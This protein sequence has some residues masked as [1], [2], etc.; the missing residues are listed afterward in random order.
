MKFRSL[1]GVSSSA[2]LISA[3]SGCISVPPDE[4]NATVRRGNAP[5]SVVD[6]Q[7]ATKAIKIYEAMP[8]DA[9]NLGDVTAI[10]CHANL[11]E[12]KPTEEIVRG[13]LLINAYA[14]GADAI[15]DMKIVRQPGNL[16]YNCYFRLVG[17]ARA[18]KA[19]K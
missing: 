9:E 17:T 16:G 11:Y 3:L 1:A 18:I 14:K 12:P 15:S 10:R 7:A 13:D 8:D 6:L 4:Q 19:N 2:L 5:S